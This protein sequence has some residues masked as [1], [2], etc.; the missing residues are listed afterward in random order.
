MNR[1]Y[2]YDEEEGRDALIELL[3]RLGL[4]SADFASTHSSLYELMKAMQGSN[5][6]PDQ[7]FMDP[8]SYKALKTFLQPVKPKLGDED[9]QT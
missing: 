7:V 4:K 2:N 3:K 8:M 5:G 9:D 1:N 6:K